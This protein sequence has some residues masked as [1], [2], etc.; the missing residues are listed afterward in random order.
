MSASDRIVKGQIA[1]FVILTV[2]SV[3]INIAI[4]SRILDIIALASFGIAI[5]LF[6]FTRDRESKPE[7][8]ITIMKPKAKEPKEETVPTDEEIKRALKEIESKED[9]VEMEPLE[10]GEFKP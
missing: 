1:L 4:Q 9:T 5:V 3:A 2:G 7:R 10:I 8:R 6:Y